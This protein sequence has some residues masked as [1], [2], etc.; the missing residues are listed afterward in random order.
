MISWKPYLILI[1]NLSKKPLRNRAFWGGTNLYDQYK[2]QLCLKIVVSDRLTI[3]VP[4]FPGSI[5]WY[6]CHSRKKKWWTCLKFWHM[7]LHQGL[8][9]ENSNSVTMN[10]LSPCRICWKT[11]MKDTSRVTFQ[12]HCSWNLL[13]FICL[14][15][16]HNPQFHIGGETWVK[17]MKS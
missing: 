1:Q 13:E 7:T 2:G 11:K 6:S 9:N 15:E 17:T 16:L 3:D 14:G 4:Y 5:L 8:W 12:L 10:Q